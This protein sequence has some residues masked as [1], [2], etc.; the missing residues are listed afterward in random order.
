[1]WTQAED[2]LLFTTQYRLGNKWKDIAK[3]IPGRSE[4]SV[5][6]RCHSAARKQWLKRNNLIDNDSNK[7]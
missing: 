7:K 6:N 1:M 3:E 5:K 4:N 2:E